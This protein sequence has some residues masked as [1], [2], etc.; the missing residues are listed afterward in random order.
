MPTRANAAKSF[1]SNKSLKTPPL[2]GRLC[3]GNHGAMLRDVAL[4]GLRRHAK[5]MSD[6][7]LR[8]YGQ[9]T[10]ER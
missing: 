9:R 10:H 4:D 3:R 2:E 6:L 7:R 1:F 5:S 8:E